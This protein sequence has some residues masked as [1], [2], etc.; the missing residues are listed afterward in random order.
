MKFLQPQIVILVVLALLLLF[1]PKRFPDLGR[2]F[3]R[4]MKAFRDD[5]KDADTDVP[6]VS[7]SKPRK[8]KKA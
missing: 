8:R 3:G 7:S 1:W 5:K 6:E 4:P 2:S